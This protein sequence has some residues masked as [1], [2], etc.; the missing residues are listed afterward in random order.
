M[1]HQSKFSLSNISSIDP[2]ISA[3]IIVHLRNERNERFL[4]EP[5]L[6]IR[7]QNLADYEII[8]G[9]DA[10]SAIGLDKLDFDYSY[11]SHKYEKL[12]SSFWKAPR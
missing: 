8:F 2:T 7:T 6:S 4:S 10:Q 1:K 12:C 5:V 9:I 11:A 3:C